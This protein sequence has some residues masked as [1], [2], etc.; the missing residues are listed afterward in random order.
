MH[1]DY[2]SIINFPQISISLQIIFELAEQF[3]KCRRIWSILLLK[4]KKKEE[5][6]KSNNGIEHWFGQI[7]VITPAF[8]II[9]SSPSVMRRFLHRVR[10]YMA[11]SLVFD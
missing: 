8:D 3:I 9:W 4:R 11:M 2:N 10:A 7:S 5:A 1:R 6:I